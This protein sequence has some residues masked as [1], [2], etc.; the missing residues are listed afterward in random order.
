[1]GT[2][3]E[4]YDGSLERSNPYF[5]AQARKGLI[6]DLSNFCNCKAQARYFHGLGAE[7]QTQTLN[8][9]FA[10]LQF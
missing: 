1:M 6:A 3:N 2:N 8:L 7:I 4:E 5:Q 10:A 9:G